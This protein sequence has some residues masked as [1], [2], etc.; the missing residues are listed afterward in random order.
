[1]P[2]TTRESLNLEYYNKIEDLKV[3]ISENNM[4]GAAA[5]DLRD[6]LDEE[7]ILK[8][9]ALKTSLLAARALR[10]QVCHTNFHKNDVECSNL[11][12]CLSTHA[13][14]CMKVAA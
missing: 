14:R 1:M 11:E 3:F 13:T 2:T 5:K 4:T 7:Y 9:R 12:T 6:Q 10:R 8:F